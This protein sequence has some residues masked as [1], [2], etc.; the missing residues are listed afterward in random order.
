[1][2]YGQRMHHEERFLL[3]DV[4]LRHGGE[5]GDHELQ[6]HAT[7]LRLRLLRLFRHELS[8]AHGVHAS[9]ERELEE[10]TRRQSPSDG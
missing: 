3:I 6:E 7:E 9:D 5:G 2:T 1:M 8:V 10:T 4:V